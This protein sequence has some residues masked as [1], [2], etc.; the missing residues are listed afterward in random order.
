[1]TRIKLCGLTSTDDIQAANALQSTYIGFVFFA[2]SKRYV[3]PE[4]AAA[5]KAELDPHIMAVGVFVDAPVDEMAALVKSG[6]IDAIQLHGH[7]DNHLIESL[8][9]LTPA[10]ILQ[11]FTIRTE[12]DIARAQASSADMILLDA[13][14]GE[15]KTFDWSLLETVS[16]PYF[17]AG[18][19]DAHN[20]AQ[21]IKKYRPYGVDTSSGIETNGRKD[22]D[23]MAAFVAAVRKEDTP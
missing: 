1:M 12:E 2:G 5:L 21:A 6:T 23:K 16:R 19:L 22:K 3:S 11:A 17:L 7:E 9:K 20:V 13:G 4:H 14:A 8:R 18:G 10:P 15:G